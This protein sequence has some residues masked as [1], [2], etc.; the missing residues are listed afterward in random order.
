MNDHYK[1]ILE[2]YALWF[3][4][5]GYNEKTRNRYAGIIAQFFEWLQA[6]NISHITLLN[7]THIKS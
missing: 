3:D 4:T 5:L 6:K 7:H 2:Q 1:T